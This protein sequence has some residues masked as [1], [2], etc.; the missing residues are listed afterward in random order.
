[1]T[2]FEAEQID[3]YLDK[4]E[5]S[6]DEWQL[7]PSQ[8]R[9]ENAELKRVL[10]Q[11]EAVSGKDTSNPHMRHYMSDLRQRISRCCGQIQERLKR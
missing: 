1:M 7:E 2:W 6:L 8:M 3:M 4:L 11:V 10:Q 9:I 5:S